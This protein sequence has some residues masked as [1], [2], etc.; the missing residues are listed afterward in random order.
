MSTPSPPQR[1]DPIIDRGLVQ[2]LAV[3]DSGFVFDPVSGNSFTVNES[4]LRIIQLVKDGKN[5][6]E[7]VSALS[8]EYH[9]SAT[10]IERDV[11][12]FVGLLRKQFPS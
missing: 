2:R 3:S 5:L 10:D 4:G 9:G 12:E 8:N 6:G 11:L 1:R 7:A